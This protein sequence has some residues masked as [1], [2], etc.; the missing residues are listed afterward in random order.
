MAREMKDSG[1][2]WIEKIPVEW[3]VKSIK[4]IFSFDKGLPITKDNLCESGVPVISYGQIHLK[5]NSG[6]YI[7][8]A[9][10]RYVSEKYLNRV[11]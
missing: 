1:V 6:I 7:D 10:L 8:S 2:A 4:A 3:D 9:L 11:Y 5:E